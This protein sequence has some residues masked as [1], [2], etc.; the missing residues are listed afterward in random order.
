VQPSDLKFAETAINNA[1]A[2]LPQGEAYHNVPETMKVGIAEI[3]EAGIAPKVTEAIKQELQ[4]K[5]KVKVQSGIRFDPGGVEMKLVVKPSEFEVF[6]VEGGK[7]FVTSSSPG[8]WIWEITPLTP[9]DHLI[10]VEAIVDLKVPE[11]NVTHPIEV[12]VFRA[13]RKVQVNPVYSTREFVSKNWK[14]IA[15]FIVG[16][17]SLVSLITWWSGKKKK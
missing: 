5:G 9:G 16:S 7:Q 13:T 14:E 12:E 11:L 15:G 1:L 8:K 6:E 3:V 17:G 10:V 2:K 4:G